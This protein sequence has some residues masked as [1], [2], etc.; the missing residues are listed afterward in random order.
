MQDSGDKGMNM[1]KD[2]AG[3]IKRR[4]YFVQKDFQSKFILKF[5][6]VLFTGIIISIGLLFLFSQNTLTSS[7]EQSRLVIK[8]TASAILPSVFL[9]HLIALVL[10]T[11]LTIVVTLLVS[12]KLAGPLFRFQKELREI[13]EGNLTQVIKLRKKDQVKAMADSLDQMR[14]NLQKKIL[15]IKEEVEQIINSTSGQDIPPDLSKRL[16]HLNQ[17][18][19]N[20]FKIGSSP[21]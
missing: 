3:H 15:D 16:D 21:D 6:M 7:F 20:N 4:Q 13:G 10:I 2:K 1:S 14:V 17:K 19:R 18:I 9:S 12:H 8:N 5:C 11:L